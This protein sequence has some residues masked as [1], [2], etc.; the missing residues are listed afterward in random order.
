MKGRKA[1][2]QKILDLRGGRTLTHR[3][4]RNEPNPSA[5]IPSCPS[6]LNKDAKKEWRRVV[7]ILGD[8]GILTELDRSTLGAYCESY[9]RWVEASKKIQEMGLIYVEGQTQDKKGNII[10]S[11]APKINP[12]VRILKDAFDQM[13][14]TGVLLGMSPSS[15]ASLSI[16]KP[17]I[18]SAQTKSEE[19]KLLKGGQK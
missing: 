18:S 1:I 16:S 15:R 2:P 4:A 19:F 17:I 5:K 14:S 6:N 13:K 11:G 8:I 9:S 3:A 10:K 12:Y 7:K